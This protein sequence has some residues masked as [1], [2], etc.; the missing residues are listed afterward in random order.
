MQTR[1]FQGI[2]AWVVLAAIAMVGLA[3][4]TNNV[5][6][7][8]NIERVRAKTLQAEF[9][10]MTQIV[11]QIIN[12]SD[13]IHNDKSITKVLQ[14]IV[15]LHP[16]VGLLTL[17]KLT[18][19]SSTPISSSDPGSTPAVLSQYERN[20]MTAGHLVFH[21]YD[22]NGD[23]GWIVTAPVYMNGQAV[24]ALQG[25]YSLRL[26]DELLE[27]EGRSAREV[28]FVAV[29]LSSLVLIWLVRIKVQNPIGDL[30]RLMRRAE[31]GNLNSHV[32]VRGSADIQELAYQFNQMLDRI[33]SGLVDRERL[34]GEIRRFNQKLI[35]TIAETRAELERTNQQLVEARLTTERAS[36]L[37][38][39]GELSSVMAHELG[40]PLNAIGGHLQLLENELG[41]R[42]PNRH[43][44]IVRTE[45]ERMVS[46]I[47]QIL[48]S[49]SITIRSGPV[50]LNIEVEKVCRLIGPSLPTHNIVLKS[51]LTPSLP[52][53]AGDNRALHG[54]IFNLANNAIQAMP[55]GGD[56]EFITLPALAS[57]V[58]PEVL[59]QGTQSIKGAVRLIIRDS[60]C[61]IS[62]EHLSRIFEPLFTTRHHEGGT[63]LGLAFCHRVIIALGGRIGV[64]S[65]IGQGTRFIIDLPAW[66][67]SDEEE[68]SS[69]GD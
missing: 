67:G 33:R 3:T 22:E 66:E 39:L 51:S 54:V 4:M 8:E 25:R 31:S 38:A 24:S 29:V 6:D 61:G 42:E 60:G 23:R 36:K 7:R 5:L 14:E 46:I 64:D 69:D 15:A 62:P 11:G 52:L 48:D 65:T 63:G 10:G 26:F 12:R 68:R 20:E 56:L 18:P 49:T 57:V 28:G 59:F 32:Q 17:Y 44:T 21:R 50:D 35:Q 45:I 41:R 58:G 53:I 9:L 40:N 30:V 1:W 16:H 43:L 19:R 13:D 47:R 2:L 27:A 55:R 34:N 37:A